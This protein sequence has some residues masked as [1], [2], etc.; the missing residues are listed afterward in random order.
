MR[1]LGKTW[2]LCLLVCFVYGC[3]KPD[4]PD[5]PAPTPKF[6]E[7]QKKPEQLVWLEKHCWTVDPKFVSGSYTL[8]FRFYTPKN[9]IG[10]LTIIIEGDEYFSVLTEG[11]EKVK[12]KL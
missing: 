6:S 2:L 8:L 1:S 7:K 11:V 9:P 5:Q 3:E 4:T 12:E 10:S